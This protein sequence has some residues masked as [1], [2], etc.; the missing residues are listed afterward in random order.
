[1]VDILFT[2]CFETGVLEANFVKPAHDKQGF[3]RT[4]VL[5]R[6]EARLLVMQKKYWYVQLI[7]S[8]KITSFCFIYDVSSR[9]FLF[10]G[11]IIAIKLVMLN[12]AI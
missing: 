2:L 11:V 4:I 6:L 5:A 7:S 1:M 9:I 3:E 8:F 10:T 12:V